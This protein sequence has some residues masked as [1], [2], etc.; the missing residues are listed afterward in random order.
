MEKNV[1]L[2]ASPTCLQHAPVSAD[3]LVRRVVGGKRGRLVTVS[4]CDAASVRLSD[5]PFSPAVYSGDGE[6]EERRK[7]EEERVE[8]EGG[9]VERGG[10]RVER[11]GGRVE[12]EG[13]RVERGGG[14]VERE[15]GRRERE[16]GRVEREGGRGKN[17]ESS[18]REEG[19]ER[20]KSVTLLVETVLCTWFWHSY[21]SL[22]P[23]ESQENFY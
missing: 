22:P 17:N 18:K 10:W 21:G 23:R 7:R 2:R 13:R 12:R 9:R 8:R 15:G 20:V 6:G 1:D 5:E 4:P 3:L 11:E 14:R 16:G 19:R